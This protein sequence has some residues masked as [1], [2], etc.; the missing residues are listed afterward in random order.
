MS[1][2]KRIFRMFPMP[3]TEE[4]LVIPYKPA[5][6]PN[7]P[8]PNPIVIG[9]PRDLT[10]AKFQRQVGIIAKEIQLGEFIGKQYKQAI[11]PLIKEV[12]RQAYVRQF[13]KI[14]KMWKALVADTKDLAKVSSEDKRKTVIVIL[15]SFQE[16]LSKA[17]IIQL[18]D[19][20]ESVVTANTANQQIPAGCMA[21]EG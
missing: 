4:G 11:D 5:E 14:Q 7:V 6:P 15:Q 12:W 20:V 9:E 19:E 13:E 16:G 21:R 2:E 1:E 8:L 18:L 17:N 3:K 10:F